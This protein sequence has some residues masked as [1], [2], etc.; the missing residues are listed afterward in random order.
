M[1]IC[2]DLRFPELFRQ[3][4]EQGRRMGVPAQ[5]LYLVYR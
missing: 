5:C 4:R 1:A 2:Y 3:L